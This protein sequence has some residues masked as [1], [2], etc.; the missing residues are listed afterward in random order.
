MPKPAAVLAKGAARATAAVKPETQEA[1][2]SS[3]SGGK[4]QGRR[5]TP[6][7]EV[8][9]GLTRA[10]NGTGGAGSKGRGRGGRGQQRG[11]RARQTKCGRARSAAVATATAAVRSPE[12][13]RQAEN[14]PAK[15]NTPM[16]QESAERKESESPD[17]QSSMRKSPRSKE[18]S[19]NR[20]ENVWLISVP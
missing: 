1:D 11:G 7:V 10:S 15:V 12:G 5:D 9:A 19:K 18:V 4:A 16:A 13:E 17:L 2:N 8:D 14:V 6:L 20:L 3:A